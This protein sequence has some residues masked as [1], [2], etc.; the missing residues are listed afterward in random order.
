M[1]LQSDFFC[2]IRK[3][4]FRLFKFFKVFPFTWDP[5][6]KLFNTTAKFQH[7]FNR[8]SLLIP[9]IIIFQTYQMAKYLKGRENS[10]IIFLY[11]VW[12]FN[13]IAFVVTWVFYWD[14]DN[15]LGFLNLEKFGE[16]T[17]RKEQL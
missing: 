16:I 9:L 17:A 1:H 12:V 13:L 8:E 7:Q 14:L 3:F 10:T 6:Q 5:H 2:K 11:M 4:Q 15:F